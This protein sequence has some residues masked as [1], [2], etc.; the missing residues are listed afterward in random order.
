MKRDNLI[1]KKIGFLMTMFLFSAIFIIAY[2]IL[3][4][5]TDEVYTDIVMEYVA[6]FSSAKTKER[7]LIY[8]LIIAGIGVYLTWHLA[9]L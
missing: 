1:K 4:G 7:N 8:I 2:L 6:H 5:N 9:V 3:F